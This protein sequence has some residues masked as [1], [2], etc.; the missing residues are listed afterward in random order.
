MP[1]MR[2]PLLA[3]LLVAGAVAAGCTEMDEAALVEPGAPVIEA[4]P[5][6]LRVLRYHDD[7]SAGDEWIEVLAPDP[8][9]VVA[10]DRFREADSRHAEED[11]PADVRLLYEAVDEGRTVLVRLNCRSCR[12]GVPTTDPDDTE[13]LVWD[14]VVGAGGDEAPVLG[15]AAATAGRAHVVPRGEHVVVV[16]S[17]DAERP[18]EPGDE[19]VLR[20]VG[21]HE[22]SKGADLLVDVFAAVGPGE[23]ALAYGSDE[24]VVRVS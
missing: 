22:P 1:A 8:T 4:D 2:P 7:P 5:G 10:T 13:V 9:V 20:F 11:Q 6:E 16:R 12:H 3:A 19:S 21:R 15:E 17:P 24:Y 18:M 14:F 23:T